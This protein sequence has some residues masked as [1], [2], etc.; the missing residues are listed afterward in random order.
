[1]FLYILIFMFLEVVDWYSHTNIYTEKKN[2]NICCVPFF[3]CH[4]FVVI[5]SQHTAL[6]FTDTWYYRLSIHSSF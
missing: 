3:L 1:M 6:K 2:M 5:R 4:C